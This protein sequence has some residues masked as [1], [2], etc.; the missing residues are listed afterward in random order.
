MLPGYSKK[1]VNSYKQLILRLLNEDDTYEDILNYV[2]VSG[3]AISTGSC[4]A[5]SASALALSVTFSH[6]SSS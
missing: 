3:Q 4:L 2:M 1:D 5:F 6:Y